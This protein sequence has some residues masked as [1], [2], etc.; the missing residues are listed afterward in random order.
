MASKE[1]KKYLSH[2]LAEWAGGLKFEQLS[3]NAVH[4]DA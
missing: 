2:P 3:D 1:S 4:T